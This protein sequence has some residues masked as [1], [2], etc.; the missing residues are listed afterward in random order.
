MIQHTEAPEIH[1]LEV[2]TALMELNERKP[3]VHAFARDFLMVSST[4]NVDD[5]NAFIQ[6]LRNQGFAT[7]FPPVH[8]AIVNTI[9]ELDF[10]I[11]NETSKSTKRKR[12]KT[13]MNIIQT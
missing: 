6:S 3:E 10:Q 5:M 8:Q 13:K 11:K 1:S 12:K 7:D 4:T 9:M 2:E